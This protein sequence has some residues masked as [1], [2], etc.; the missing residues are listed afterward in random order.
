MISG[1]RAKRADLVGGERKNRRAVIGG[2][3]AKIGG[4]VW[5]RAKKWRAVIGGFRA[6]I[7]RFSANPNRGPILAEA[8]GSG[9]G[10][11]GE[12]TGS[13]RGVDGAR[14]T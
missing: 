11:D 1:F 9:R 2:F 14:L 4:F 10:V 12:C 7:Y 8:D 5:G 6:K 3:R 13:G